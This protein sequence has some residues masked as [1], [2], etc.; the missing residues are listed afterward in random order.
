MAAPERTVKITADGQLQETPLDTT[1]LLFI[2][3]KHKD[4]RKKMKLQHA[5][6]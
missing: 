3:G 5:A 6:S 1:R 2:E 4:W